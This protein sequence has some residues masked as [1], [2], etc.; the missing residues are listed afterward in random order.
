MKR[1]QLQA[2]NMRFGPLHVTRD[3]SFDISTGERAAIIGPNG[4]GKTT[5][6]NII[7]GELHHTSGQI[8]FD[9]EDVG[10]LSVAQRAQRGLVRTFQIS[11][12]FTGLTVEEN[13]R[14]AALHRKQ[15]NKP[16]RDDIDTAVHAGMSKL[17]ISHLAHKEVD[18]LSL[19]EKRLVELSLA[20]TQSPSLLLLDEP[21]AGIPRSESRMVLDAVNALPSD[22]PVILIEHD[23]DLVFSWA[24]RIIV[25]A[26][27]AVLKDGD[28]QLIAA[29]EHVQR[30]YFGRGE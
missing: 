28:P 25:L 5:L 27:G 9:G 20:L 21:A 10:T 22:L 30:I 15:E 26:G 13:V 14:V 12:L 19:G 18:S 7:A 2:V 17:Q 6:V 8:L 16:S 3:V 23:M 4:A 11:R 1:L 24:K 29:D